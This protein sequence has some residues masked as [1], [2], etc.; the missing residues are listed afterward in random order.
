MS[1]WDAT[2]P[3]LLPELS[4]ADNILAVYTRHNT[5]PYGVDSDSEDDL[6]IVPDTRPAFLR[7]GLEDERCLATQDYQQYEFRQGLLMLKLEENGPLVEQD[8]W[9]QGIP[10]H[11]WSLLHRAETTVVDLA[12][13]FFREKRFPL[14]I[15]VK[16]A[17]YF[18]EWYYTRGR[19]YF[20]FFDAL[21][22]RYDD[23][24]GDWDRLL[25][26]VPN[27]VYASPNRGYCFRCGE[28]SLN[29]R[30]TETHHLGHRQPN[31]TTKYGLGIM[32]LCFNC[33]NVGF[34]FCTFSRRLMYDLIR[35]PRAFGPHWWMA[36]YECEQAEK[37]L[38]IKNK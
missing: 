31:R 38:A 12:I 1:N 6:V 34:Q 35:K 33:N 3:R 27:L 23:E 21:I 16:I 17:G 19:D 28:A 15:R 7:Y 5:D 2:E 18:N 10:S 9:I 8:I 32:G 29:K 14:D 13:W 4:K 25:R 26:Q 37:A 22:E 36:D 24:M 30:V 20:P 11:R